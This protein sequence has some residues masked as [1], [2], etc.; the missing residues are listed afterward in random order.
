MGKLEFVLRGAVI[1][2][3][4]ALVWYILHGDK[5]VVLVSGIISLIMLALSGDWSKVPTNSTTIINEEGG[6]IDNSPP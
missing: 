4:F 3:G 6:E 5:P 1:I 2:G